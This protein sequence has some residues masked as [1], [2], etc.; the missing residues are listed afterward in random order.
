[1]C[2]LSNL[3]LFDSEDGDGQTSH[4]NS[5]S[6][7]VSSVEGDTLVARNNRMS[8]AAAKDRLIEELREAVTARDDFL[9]VA[10]HELK[11]PLTPIMLSLE[12]VRMAEKSG[13]R[14]QSSAELD[15]LER[16]IKHFA[17]RTHMLLEVAQIS[18]KKLQLEAAELNLSELVADVVN[19]YNLLIV[20]SGSV[21]ISSIQNEIVGLF[22]RMAVSRIVENLLTNAVKYGRGRPIELTLTAASGIAQIIVRDNGIGIADGDTE[23][24]FNRFERAVSRDTHSGFG[25]GLW[26]VRNLAESMD[27]SITVIGE[28]GVGSTFTVNLPI[29]RKEIYE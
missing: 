22:D 6:I 17:S 28:S 20:R 1:L 10:A 4:D 13:N 25:V 3:G 27:G 18:S 2:L 23:R 29:K 16:L 21:M 15:R 8:D 9:A 24:I 7:P 14:S 12:L 19:D 26:L 5:G 11:N